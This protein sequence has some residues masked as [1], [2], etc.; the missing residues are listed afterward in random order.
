MAY[1]KNY[2]YNNQKSLVEFVPNE[3]KTSM[4]N[5]QLVI[6]ITNIKMFMLASVQLRSRTID[7]FKVQAMEV[8]YKAVVN[9]RI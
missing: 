8:N 2:Q 5:D 6:L 4:A 3:H 9:I 7:Y 1:P